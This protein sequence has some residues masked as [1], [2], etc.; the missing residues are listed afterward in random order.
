MKMCTTSNN[1]N[2]DSEETHLQFDSVFLSQNVNSTLS[3][4]YLTKKESL[5]LNFNS[6]LVF[7]SLI[8]NLN[9]S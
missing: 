3:L 4:I 1:L 7:F 6:F 5:L 2:K 8:F 9:I